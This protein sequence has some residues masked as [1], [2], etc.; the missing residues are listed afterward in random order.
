[1][2]ESTSLIL[3]GASGDLSRRKLVPALFSLYRKGRLPKRFKLLGMSTSAMSHADY[4]ARLLE[5]VQQFAE[6]TF[7]PDE[8]HQFSQGLFYQPGSF[9]EP[10][11]YLKLAETLQELEDGPA[12]RLFYLATPPD[13]FSVIP[14]HLH[15]AGMLEEAQGW[16]RVVVEKPFGTDLASAEALNRDLHSVLDEDQIYR[17]DHY[18][19][20]ETVQN[21]LTF[22]FA[23]AI[24]E[25]IWNRDHIDHVQIT[26][27]EQVDVGSRAKYYDGVGALR[28]MFQNHLFQLLSFIALEPPASFNARD[29]REEKLKVLR[30]VRPIQPQEVLQAALRGQYRGYRDAQGIAPDSRTETYAALRLFIDNWRWQGVPFYLRSGKGL[31]EKLSEIIIQFKDPPARL[32]ANAH[33]SLSTPNILSFCLQPDEGIHQRFEVKIPDTVSDHRSVEMQFHYQDVF[34]PSAIPEAYERLLLD[35]LNG[36]ATLFNRADQAELAWALLSPVLEAWAKPDGPPLC[37][38]DPGSWGPAEADEF[39]Q[40]DGRRWWQMC[41]CEAHSPMYTEVVPGEHMAQSG[42]K[43]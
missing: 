22:R 26:V 21:I 4:R 8:W 11:A 16:Q 42:T 41:S 1:M 33:A 3:F 38:Y 15:A 27:A 37:E 24:Y 19:G 5:G 7:T 20:K 12:N 30:A 10:Q 2:S 25:P 18:L 13:F 40:R 17:I 32:F 36:D 39:L 9:T 34:S 23:N 43:D 14:A 6:Y 29:L 35:A 31:H 28:D